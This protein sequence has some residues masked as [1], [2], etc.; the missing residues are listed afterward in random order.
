MIYTATKK[1]HKVPQNLEKCRSTDAT[2]IYFFSNR[3][4]IRRC[5]KHEF[6]VSFYC[7]IATTS[8]PSLP[9]R[10]GH[11]VYMNL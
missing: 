5:L 3:E 1:N 11:D 7:L 8:G 4:Q 10:R 2:N 9:I 6:W